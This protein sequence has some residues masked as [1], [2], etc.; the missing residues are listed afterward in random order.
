MDGSPGNWSLGGSLKRSL[1]L[2]RNNVNVYATDIPEPVTA[3]TG[4]IRE[5][6]A[7][8][9]EAFKVGSATTERS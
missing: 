8:V 5:V 4:E 6:A 7:A 3:L 2:L 1:L 9:Q